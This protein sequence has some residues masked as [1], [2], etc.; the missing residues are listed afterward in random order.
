MRALVPFELS[1][2]PRIE[3]QARIEVLIASNI[4]PAVGFEVRSMQVAQ[5]VI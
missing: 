5:L 2:L 3:R 4:L 1:Y